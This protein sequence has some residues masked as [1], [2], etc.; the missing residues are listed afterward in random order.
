MNVSRIEVPLA[1][2]EPHFEDEAT[3]VS[4]RQVVPLEQARVQDRRRKLLAIL[5]MLL[6]ATF[7]GGLGALAVNYFERRSSTPAISQPSSSGATGERQQVS[8]P[9]SPDNR[10]A[11]STGSPGEPDTSQPSGTALATDS[12]A[13]ADS[14]ESSN[15]AKSEE[16]VASVKKPSSSTDP[17]QLVRPRRV[18]PPSL[19]PRSGQNDQPKSRGAARI[20]D[21]FSGPNP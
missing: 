17:K 20:Q 13:A 1:L 8:P 19:Q 12:P 15:A 11:T 6:A 9:A 14:L 3:V 4:A 7:C 21:I 10:T 16:T 2:P 5:P 18:R